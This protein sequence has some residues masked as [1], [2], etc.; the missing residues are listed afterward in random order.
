MKPCG[1]D[2]VSVG[3]C[4]PGTVRVGWFDMAV[5]QR[6]RLDTAHGAGTLSGLPYDTSG[7][8]VVKRRRT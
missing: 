7:F 6:G 3:K 8:H 4:A 1:Q 2:S 5:L